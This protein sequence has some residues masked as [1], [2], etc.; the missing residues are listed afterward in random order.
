M[1][2]N[3]KNR[4]SNQLVRCPS[5]YIVL[6]TRCL[7]GCE[8][9]IIGIACYIAKMNRS[10]NI[11][12]VAPNALINELDSNHEFSGIRKIE[13]LAIH[14]LS[15][16]RFSYL[17]FWLICFCFFWGKPR[18]IT[19]HYPLVYPL[20]L[21]RLFNHFAIVSWVANCAPSCKYKR[22]LSRALTSLS[23]VDANAIDI[24]NPA[25]YTLLTEHPYLRQKASLTYGG[26]HVDSQLYKPR[27][28][29]YMATFLGRLIPEKQG[30][31]YVQLLPSVCSIL[32]A[33]SL[34]VPFF[35]ICGW[36]EEETAI[37]KLIATR[38]YSNISIKLFRSDKPAEVLSK[39]MIFFSLQVSSNY[40]SRAL[41]E[42]MVA[43]AFPVLTE[44]P[45]SELMI[46]PSLPHVFIPVDFTACDIASAIESAWRFREECGDDLFNT[47]SDLSAKRFSISRQADYFSQIYGL[48]ALAVCN[49][50]EIEG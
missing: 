49:T 21:K 1:F 36:G 27:A 18:G 38:E 17:E 16:Q 9:R 19:V 26:T 7:A 33:K 8:K 12:I 24:L 45:D 13:N 30:L 6:P 28:K 5:I 34:P 39:T 40:P 20:L 35:C 41:A 42:S 11:H 44:S 22:R 23:F 32:E 2:A 25:I 15:G 31:R 37:R 29:E 3:R 4:K 50:G 43:G 48:S 10:A 46:E 47:I 14:G